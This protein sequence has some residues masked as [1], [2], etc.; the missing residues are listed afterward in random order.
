MVPGEAT[1]VPDPNGS[2]LWL[3]DYVKDQKLTLTVN[4]PEDISFIIASDGVEPAPTD[5]AVSWPVDNSTPW[6]GPL[7]VGGAI[8]LLVGIGFLIWATNHMRSTRGPRRKMPKVPK[9][10]VYKPSP[11]GR[12]DARQRSSP[13]NDRGSSRTDRRPHPER[14][15]GGLLAQPRRE[16]HPVTVRD[17]CPAAS[18]LSPPAVTVRQIERIIARISAVTTE[19]DCQP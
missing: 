3:D 10:P 16:G 19:A 5:L 14:M 9:K 6:A 11:Q 8:V 15:L 12:R 13:R 2:D 1:E 17:V 18:E 4:V 7:I